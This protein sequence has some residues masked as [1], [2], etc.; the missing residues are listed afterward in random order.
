LLESPLGNDAGD[1]G[2]VFQIHA[3][4]DVGREFFECLDDGTLLHG[5]FEFGDIAGRLGFGA[6]GE[7]GAVILNRSRYGAARWKLRR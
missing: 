2:L 3:L 5:P 4:L 1:G 7:K 6:V